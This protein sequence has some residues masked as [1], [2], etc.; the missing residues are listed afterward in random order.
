MKTLLALSLA[1]CVSTADAKPHKTVHD[2]FVR[3]E[4]VTD[5]DML[6][7]VRADLD[8]AVKDRV[9]TLRVTLTSPGGPVIT[10][11]EIAR[12]VRDASDKGDRKSV[13]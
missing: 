7:Q 8:A 2:R 9:K 12:L 1:L 3:W 10:S 6:K 5:L 4:G 11:L 13:V